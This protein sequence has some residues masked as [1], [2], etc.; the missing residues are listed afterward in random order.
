MQTVFGT[1]SRITIIF[2]A[3]LSSDHQGFRR[4]RSLLLLVRSSPT[5][6]EHVSQ[7]KYADILLFLLSKIAHRGFKF[8]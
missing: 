3:P 7:A 6:L 4:Y 8:V 1:M 5:K 2:V